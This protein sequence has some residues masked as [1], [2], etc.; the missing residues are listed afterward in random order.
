MEENKNENIQDPNPK[1]R[2]RIFIISAII[3]L[4][5]AG[6][7]YFYFNREKPV[8]VPAPVEP[9]KEAPIVSKEPEQIEPRM[10]ESFKLITP[11]AGET[12]CLNSNASYKISWEAP[13][14]LQQIKLHVITPGIDAPL[15]Q[16][17]AV[18]EVRNGVGYGELIWNL[19]SAGGYPITEKDGYRVL[20]AGEYKEKGFRA[21]ASETFSMKTCQ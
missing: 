7:L 9:K 8:V 21:F 18:K 6:G 10:P 4:L 1:K 17:P 20:I 11:I 2:K 19:K 14:D 5:I 12:V 3:V 16:F 15:G 13:P